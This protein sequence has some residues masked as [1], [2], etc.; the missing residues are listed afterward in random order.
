M[1]QTITS[2]VLL[3]VLTFGALPDAEPVPLQTTRHFYL[4]QADALAKRVKGDDAAKR[5]AAITAITAVNADTFVLDQYFSDSP[6]AAGLYTAAELN[7][8]R[9][10]SSTPR[11]LL[12]YFSVGEAESYRP[13]WN[14]AW[15][16]RHDGK[17]D[18][19]APDFLLEQNKQFKGNYRVK[20]WKANWQA[21]L[22]GSDNAP[23]DLIIAQGFDGV[24]LDIIDGFESFED[25]EDNRVN[26]ETGQTY[27]RDM[28]DFVKKIAD[29]ARAKK[30]GFFVVPQNGTQLLA[31]DDHLATISG[32]GQEDLYYNA[33]KLNKENAETV[34]FLK[35]V[36]T[37]GKAVLVT[38]YPTAK[39]KQDEDI[40][41]AQTDGFSLFIAKRALNSLGRVP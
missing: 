14:A 27:R 38:D 1:V 8:I 41:L 5:A 7:Q 34:A 33:N 18:A 3:L 35:K 22:M 17:P 29:Y 2:T 16:A 10:G 25:G 30:P 39:R 31:F 32:Q 9:A 28:I 4:L 23:L 6:I 20:Y 12:C 24:Y 40:G 15:D 36:R 21:L 26:P 11:N 13:Y 37:A 19:G